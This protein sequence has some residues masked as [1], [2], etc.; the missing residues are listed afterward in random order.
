MLLVSADFLDSDYCYEVEMQRAMERH[1]ADE[2]RVIPV[3]LRACDWQTAP[4]GKLQ[5][6]PKNANPVTSWDNADEAFTNV[7]KGIRRVVEELRINR[8]GSA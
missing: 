7:A 6:L 2:A 3:I 1:K 5:A 4:F 8:E